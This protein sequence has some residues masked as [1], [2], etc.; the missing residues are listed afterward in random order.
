MV[1][2]GSGVGCENT[3]GEATNFAPH[4]FKSERSPQKCIRQ[5]PRQE[6]KDILSPFQ[7]QPE[8]IHESLFALERGFLHKGI[9]RGPPIRTDLDTPG[10]SLQNKDNLSVRGGFSRNG[11][12]NGHPREKRG[13]ED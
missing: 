13:D 9:R 12:Q 1:R 6:I 5:Y 4:L 11:G 3:M 8:M 7:G 2:Q 10:R